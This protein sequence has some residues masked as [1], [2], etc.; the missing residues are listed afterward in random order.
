MNRIGLGVLCLVLFAGSTSAAPF[1][2]EVTTAGAKGETV[3]SADSYTAYLCTA[4]AAE[5]YFGGNSS[6][7]GITSW[8]SGGD[9]FAS[10]WSALIADG[11]AMDFCGFDGDEYSF[12]KYFESSLNDSYLAVLAYDGDDG[13]MFRVFGNSAAAD[14]TLTMDPGFGAGSAGDWTSMS[15]T[16][17]PTS[18]LLL[19]LG[20]AGLAL[21]RGRNRAR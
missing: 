11:I 19:L 18:G 5:G 6:V 8:L 9:N 4:V 21:K 20:V 10:G 13:S 12:T 14:G 16:P 2:A 1:W 7:D 3:G 15:P 17:E